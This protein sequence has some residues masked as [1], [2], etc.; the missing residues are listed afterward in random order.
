MAFRRPLKIDND[1]LKE[2]SD[3]D[4]L[5]LRLRAIVNHGRKNSESGNGT[6]R[7]W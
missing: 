2:M 3:D 6:R 7:K 1:N 4:I 5:K